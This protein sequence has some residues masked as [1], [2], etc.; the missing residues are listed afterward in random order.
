MNDGVGPVTGLLALATVRRTLVACAS[1]SVLALGAWAAGAWVAADWRQR[2]EAA[3]ARRDTVRDQM[4]DSGAEGWSGQRAMYLRLRER[5]VFDPADPVAWIEAL[6]DAAARLHLPAP[7]FELA[8]RRPAEA[9]GLPDY[10]D[11]RFKLSGIHEGQLLRLLEG[12]AERSRH[13]LRVQK[14][15]MAR[16]A[17][18]AGIVADCTLRWFVF[19]EAAAPSA[20]AP[21][22]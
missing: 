22:R 5:G 15:A 16:A 6:N 10:H 20:E 7:S 8:A 2:V 11:L 14:C 13:A 17:D 9:D 18:D 19:D 12:V 3:L 4:R 1:A 21:E